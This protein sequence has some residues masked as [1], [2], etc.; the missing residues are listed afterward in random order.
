MWSGRV[1]GVGGHFL[2]F[3]SVSFLSTS[4]VCVILTMQS[5]L[6]SLGDII[7]AFVQSTPALLFPFRLLLKITQRFSKSAVLHS[8]ELV[9]GW[10]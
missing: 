10:G 1:R 5:P 7:P 9:A 8:P 2:L 4:A 6:L 3:R